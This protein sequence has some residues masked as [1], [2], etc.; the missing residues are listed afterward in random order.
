MPHKFMEEGEEDSFGIGQSKDKPD[1]FQLCITGFQ[2]TLFS[3]E[4]LQ[5]SK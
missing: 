3:N 4:G 1:I 5:M 2:K